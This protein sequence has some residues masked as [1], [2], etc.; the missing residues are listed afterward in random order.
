[1][2]RSVTY[3]TARTIFFSLAA[4][5]STAT[6]ALAQH[7][8]ITIYHHVAD[9]T[10]R[11]TSLTAE[12]LRIQMEYLRDNEFEVWPLDRLITALQ[13]RQAMPERVVALTF[14]DAYSSIYETAFP[15]LQEFDYPFALFVSTQPINDNQRGYMTWDQIRDMSEAGVLIANHMVHHSHMVD[16]Q[17]GETDAE[18]IA[19]L[20]DELRTAQRHIEQETGQS[21]KIMA[22]PYGEYDDDITAMI[23]EEGFVALAQNSG[24]V[25]YYSDFTALPRYPLAGSYADIESAATKLQSLAFKVEEVDP[26]S[27]MT[28]SRNP[29][30]TLQLAGDFNV[31]QLGCYAS[32]QPLEMEWLDREA[33]RFHIKPSDEQRFDMRRFGY[34]CTAP[35]RGT[36][37]Y[38][39]FN[40]LWIRS[41]PDNAD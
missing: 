34:I 7:A 38:Y 20:R 15:M 28:D 27:P 35:K 1:M 14:D 26:R 10:P 4:L 21:H 17:A 3:R 39:W 12:E 22:Y 25:G 9:D 13:Q 16:S 8:A 24:A 36:D 2:L 18:R 32:G 31:S 41:T 11:S 30:V 29:G 33:V 6:P 37:R 19:R 23:E 40:K 5:A